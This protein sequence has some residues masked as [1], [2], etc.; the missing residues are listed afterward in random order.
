MS[1][2]FMS[3]LR[4]LL[5]GWG[6]RVKV[7]GTLAVALIALAVLAPLL[8]PHDPNTVNPLNT[9]APGSSQHLLGTDQFGRD[10]LSRLIYGSRTAL[11]GPLVVVMISTVTG[12]ALGIAAAWHRGWVDALVG[13]LF[14][15]TFSFPSLLLALLIV[16]VMSPGLL[17]AAIAISIAYVP[18]VGRLTRASALREVNEPY[19]EALRLQGFS[20]LRICSRHVFRNISG[21]I[22]AQATMS[23]GFAMVDL[24]GIS[25]LGLG[26]QEPTADWGTMIN[27][28]ES[29]IVQGH[30]Q[31]ALYAGAALVLAAVTFIMIGDA[32]SERFES[33]VDEGALRRL[34]AGSLRLRGRRRTSVAPADTAS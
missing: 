32:L 18:W 12:A 17:S 10:L 34:F 33:S 5:R 6:P 20:T 7:A 11:L 2:L 9:L 25:F 22:L 16:T 26:V 24:A 4:E 3:R 8:A 23:F 1:M 15:L 29:S 30:P 14:D 13:R 27:A 19:V 28:G 31:E 21:V